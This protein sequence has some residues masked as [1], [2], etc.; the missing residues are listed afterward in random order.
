M[1]KTA[2]N[3][4]NR[5]TIVYLGIFL[6][7]AWIRSLDVGRPAD[8]RV[9]EL[10][11]ECDYAAV[12]RNFFREG[13]NILYPRIDWR[14][15]GPGFAEME[16]PVIPWTMAALYKVFG[17]QEV[18]GRLFIY[19]FSL[20]ALLIFFF[21][22]RRLLPDWGALAASLFFALSPLA[23]RVSNSLQPEGPMLFFYIAAAFAFIRW[24]EE[25]RWIWYG[26]ALA[27]TALAALIKIPAAHIILFF[28]LFLWAN[29]GFKALWS[30]KVWVFAAL[31]LLPSL[32]WYVHAHHLWLTYGNSLGVS[33]EYHWLGWDLVKEP[34]IISKFLFG[35][36]KNEIL[37]VWMPLG[38]I[39]ALTAL[40]DKKKDKVVRDALLW[41]VVLGLYYLVTIRTTADN[42][43]AYYHVV[44]IPA[45]SLLVGAGAMILRDRLL[46]DLPLAISLGLSLFFSLAVI[47]GRLLLG[48]TFDGFIR[49]ALLLIGLSVV[50]AIPLFLALKSLRIFGL[51]LSVSFVSIFPFQAVQIGRDLHP[52]SFQAT[53]ACAKSFKPFIPE[54]AKLLALGGPAKDETGRPVAYNAPQLFFWTDRKG[55]NLPEDQLSL[56][57]VQSYIRRGAG[58]L[59]LEKD[60]LKTKPGLDKEL[61]S[62][63]SLLAECNL[64]Y[65]FK[66]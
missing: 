20:L 10:W 19:S 23:V 27:A 33:N 61:Q 45:A 2:R 59:I 25:G 50:S 9:R 54:G 24:L 37:F 13:M 55:F 53:Y 16:F 12:A 21:L 26:T 32:L 60:A 36:A 64:M 63:F 57:R 3:N 40:W 34:V 44:T 41:L 7:G 49:P 62:R 5:T 1:A 48:V 15:D 38:W 22:A 14:G 6:L 51:V 47:A 18:L 52:D 39:A 58:Y 46:K 4:F 35:L 43:A 29:K 30:V 65:L 28:V 66:L 8:G 11:R 17:Y 56:D 42:W 31:A